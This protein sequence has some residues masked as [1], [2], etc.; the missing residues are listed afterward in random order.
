[1]YIAGKLGNSE[2]IKFKIFDRKNLNKSCT[3]AEANLEM[4]GGEEWVKEYSTGK[5]IDFVLGRNMQLYIIDENDNLIPCDSKRFYLEF[6][7]ADDLKSK[8]ESDTEVLNHCIRTN[9]YRNGIEV[10]SRIVKN[11]NDLIIH[12]KGEL[13]SIADER[14]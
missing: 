7:T 9:D 6:W 4:I 10:A 8:I 13:I 14:G 11:V 1:M 2:M 5:L 3:P 12:N